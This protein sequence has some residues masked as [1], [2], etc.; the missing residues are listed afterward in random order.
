MINSLINNYHERIQID[1]LKIID[2]DGK[3]YITT[4][5]RKIKK[6]VE[7][8]YNKTFK[9]RKSNYNNLNAEW[10]KQYES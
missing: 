1:R 6:G 8:Y 2:F 3:E 4:D 10:K 9:R 7:E 5:P